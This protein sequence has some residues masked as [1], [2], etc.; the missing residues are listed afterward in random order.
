[1]DIRHV[2]YK[3]IADGGQ[4]PS[5]HIFFLNII[6]GKVASTTVYQKCS[7]EDKCGNYEYACL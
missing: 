7:E 3:S 2:K 5:S 4:N 6:P 1:M